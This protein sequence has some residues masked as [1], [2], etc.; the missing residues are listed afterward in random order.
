MRLMASIVID[1][2]PNPHMAFGVGGHRCLGS[3]L[4]RAEL[5]IVLV[6]ALDRLPDFSVARDA[7]VGPE[8]VGSSCRRRSVPVAF[9]AGEKVGPAQA[10]V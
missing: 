6:K 8:P 5:R 1:R 3:T 2:A 4:A 10:M 9:A 7:V